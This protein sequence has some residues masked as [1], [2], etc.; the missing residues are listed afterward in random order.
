MSE[1]ASRIEAAAE[2]AKEQSQTEKDLTINVTDI[3][4]V[5]ETSWGAVKSSYQK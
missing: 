1:L 2:V 5:E 4:A 3:T